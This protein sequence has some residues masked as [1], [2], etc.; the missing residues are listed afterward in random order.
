MRALPFG[1]GLVST[2]FVIAAALGLAASA[3]AQRT[4]CVTGL[5]YC[6]QRCDL[7][8]KPESGERPACASTCI[9]N[10]QQCVRS[11]AIREGT[12]GPIGTPGFSILPGE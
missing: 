11:A 9:A 2:A 8:V 4:D 5:S 12:T 6:A 10:Y 3:N 7:K 1:V